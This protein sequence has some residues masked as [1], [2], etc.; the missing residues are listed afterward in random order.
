VVVLANLSGFDGSPESLRR[1]QL[2]Y[3]AEIGRAIVNFDGPIVFCVVSRYHGGAFVVFSGA[4]NE[5]IEVAAIEG[6][7]AS[8]IGGAPA[9]A[10]VFTREVDRR[11]RSDLRVRAAEQAVADSAPDEV[12]QR[13]AEAA[14]V[15]EAVRTEKLGEVAAEFD[16]IH[17]VERARAVGSVHRIIAAGDLRPELVAALERGMARID[18]R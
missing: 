6:S 4:L 12:G 2:E 11:T 16:A 3:G 13:R 9:A 15:R 5:R 8:V 14:G 1:L 10:V 17:S 7:R 18:A